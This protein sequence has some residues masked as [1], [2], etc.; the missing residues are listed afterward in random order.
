M[1]IPQ[2]PQK[3]KKKKKYIYILRTSHEHNLFIGY[4]A[5]WMLCCCVI[6]VKLGRVIGMMAA[7]DLA[8]EMFLHQGISDL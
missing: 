6:C 3:K 4:N 1:K 5:I 7:D 8:T 2:Q